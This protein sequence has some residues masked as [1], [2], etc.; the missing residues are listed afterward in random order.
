[1]VRRRR[2]KNTKNVGVPL[3]PRTAGASKITK[4]PR[5]PNGASVVSAIAARRRRVERKKNRK[6]LGCA[7]GASRKETKTKNKRGCAVKRAYAP[8]RAVKPTHRRCVKK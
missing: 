5:A 6:T 8:A 7:A 2:V 3:H 4:E 1:M